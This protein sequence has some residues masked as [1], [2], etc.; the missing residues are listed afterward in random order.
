MISYANINQNIGSVKF[1]IF[2]DNSTTCSELFLFGIKRTVLGNSGL[3]RTLPLQ[4]IFNFSMISHPSIINFS[5]IWVNRNLANNI[6]NRRTS[7]ILHKRKV[8]FITGPT[9]V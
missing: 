3:F 1:Y 2:L 7:Y 6:L 4:Y 8:E 5:N 9:N